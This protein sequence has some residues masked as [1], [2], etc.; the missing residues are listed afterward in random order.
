ME[1]YTKIKINC[2][3][4]AGAGASS[5]WYLTKAIRDLGHELTDDAD[6]VINVSSLDPVEK[7]PGKPYFLWDCDSFW[8][9][10]PKEDYDRVFISGSPEDLVR[11][12]PGTIFLPHAFDEQIHRPMYVVKDYDIV[13]IGCA[14]S[15]YKKRNK[16]VETL[17]SNFNVLHTQTDFGKDYAI[18]MS[19]GKLIFDRSLEDNIPMRFFEGMAI[20]VLLE[21][22]NKYL[23]EYATPGKHFIE[24]NK[25]NLVE[26]A[27]HYLKNDDDR[28]QMRIDSRINALE[29]HTYKHR[30]L[31]IL[32]ELKYL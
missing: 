29:K 5:A 17:A 26:K 6:L 19:R 25:H 2:S 7:I 24:Y 23:R 31:R 32:D 16:L 20:G 21:N 3:I 15:L 11:Y 1:R 27:D 18:E 12:D 4:E 30:V 22:E 28:N 8:H 14:S 10:Q 13:M 9:R